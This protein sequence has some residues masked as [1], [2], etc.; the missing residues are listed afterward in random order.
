MIDNWFVKILLFPFSLIYRLLIEI[1]NLLY[2]VGLLKS[3]SFDIPVISVGNLNT[4]GS[5]KTPMIEYLIRYLDP[6]IEIGVLS[7]GYKRNTKGYMNVTL[8]KTYKDVGDEPLFLKKKYPNT[9]VAVGEERALAIPQ[10]LQNYDELQ[11]ILLD[12][13]F[14][15]RGVTPY[16]NLLLTDY[17]L[18][19]TKDYLLPMGRLREP[20]SQMSRASAIIVTKCPQDL[21]EK[22]QELIVKEINPVGDQKIFFSSLKYHTAYNI[23]DTS[24]RILLDGKSVFLLTGIANPLPMIDF[25]KGK[26]TAYFH[27][28]FPDHY[29]YTKHDIAT[30]VDSYH[31]MDGHK[32]VFLT[33]EKDLIRLE[34]HF[35]YFLKHNIDIFALPIEVVFLN[36]ENGFLEWLK[37][38]LMKFRV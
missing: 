7:R 3:I 18:R 26:T 25:I 33:T 16:V 35:H 8:Q 29:A 1:R 5:G 17:N 24:Q 37:N 22:E 32:K 12:D 31:K 34:P 11:A 15:H 9:P 13:A 38:E 14:Q 28:K 36:R 21:S 30:V 20:R 23:A 10:M 6:Y 27:R 19:F 4:G 2:N